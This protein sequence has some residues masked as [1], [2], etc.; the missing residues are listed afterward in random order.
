MTLTRRLLLSYLAVVAATSAVLIFAADSMLRDRLE[1]EATLE[2]EREARYLAAAVTAAGPSRLDSLVHALGAATQ[3]RLTVVD[4]AG[5]VI[6]DSDF[7]HDQ[8]A[9]LENHAD[10]PE[11]A[12]AY[13][14]R[15][16]VDLRLSTSTGRAELKVAIAFDSLVARVSS[17]LPQVDAVVRRAQGA[18]LLGGLVAAVIAAG[19]SWGFSRRVARPLL[20]L[21]GAAQSIARGEHPGV[22]TRGRDEVGELARALR[23]VDDNLSA[24]LEALQQERS[25]M[26]ALIASMVEGVLACDGTGAI[27]TANPAARRLLGF[28]ELA[29][30]PPVQQLFRARLAQDA[31]RLTLDGGTVDGHEVE[32]AATTVLLSGRGLPGGGAVFVLHDITALK[33][34]E[35]VRRDFVANVSH[36]LKTPL[37]VVRG[38]AET[39][40]KDDPPAD[41]RAQFLKAMLDNAHRMQRLIDDLLDLSR[42]ESRA[43]EPQ[44]DAVM[45][46]PLA[47]DVWRAIGG[48]ARLVVDVAEAPDARLDPDAARQILTNVL[49]NAAR[50]TPDHGTVTVRS[51]RNDGAVSIAISDTGSGIPRE[52]LPR[53][54]ERF[55]RVDPHRSREAGGTGLGLAIVKHLTE[56]HGG[57]VEAESRIGA[58]TTIRL[59]FPATLPTGPSPV[60]PS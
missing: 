10:R 19:L 51:Q 16:G 26:A 52:H 54:F 47:E 48:R 24:R 41:M 13:E 14:G 2:L 15:T 45:L 36:E 53:I 21:S 20:R 6:A 42:I 38:Y 11:I 4:R 28:D 5:R 22:D 37:T 32:L 1:H 44:P 56:A 35:A 3:R 27:R 23:T 9:G 25:R 31:V 58:G 50:Y 46:A 34:L 30:L 8:L 17:P 49:E 40:A 60:T 55:Y 29:P 12:A 59:Q 39:L 7:R 33:R 18:I 57:R 43:W